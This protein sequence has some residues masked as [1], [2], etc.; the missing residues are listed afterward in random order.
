MW[1]FMNRL[2]IIYSLLLLI[3]CNSCDHDTN[4]EFSFRT[5]DKKGVHLNYSLLEPALS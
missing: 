2:G 4:E 5:D 3:F 1:H